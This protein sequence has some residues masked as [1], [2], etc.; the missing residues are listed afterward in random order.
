MINNKFKENQFAAR[1]TLIQSVF[2]LPIVA[3]CEPRKPEIKIK[4]DRALTDEERKWKQKFRGMSGGELYADAAP[5]KPGVMIFNEKGLLFFMKG[6]M[7]VRTN[8]K[9]SYGAEFGVP[10]TLR[11]TW[12]DDE[13][14]QPGK[15]ENK[16]VNTGFRY[17]GGVV[18]GDVTVPVA[19]RIPD[20]LL[21][22]MRKYQCGFILKLRLTDE[23]LLIGWELRLGRSYPFA[24]DTHGNAYFRP[25]IDDTAGGDF[26]ERRIVT[27]AIPPEGASAED[28]RLELPD[29]IRDK[30]TGQKVLTGF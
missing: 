30:K 9:Q 17:E 22:K 3:G 23:T 25:E 26:C 2:A 21:D 12:R 29:W 24:R 5:E 6:L 18:L 16:V 15:P 20:E 28:I 13:A 14:S 8:S 4:S 10:I 27:R 19:E 7:S 1:R 11:A